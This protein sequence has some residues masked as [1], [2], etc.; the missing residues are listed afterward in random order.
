MNNEIMLIPT[1]EQVEWLKEGDL[2]LNCF[3]RMVPVVRIAYRGVDINGRAYVGFYTA[4]GQNGTLS[5]SYKEGEL[6]RTVPLCSRYTSH[7]LDVIERRAR[8]ER[9]LDALAEFGEAEVGR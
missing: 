3:G 1:R 7:E 9:T 8:E 2:A 6:V 4:F 5:G